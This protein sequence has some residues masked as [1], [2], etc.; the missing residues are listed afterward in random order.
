MGKDREG[1]FHPSKGKPSGLGKENSVELHLKEDG[2]LDQYLETAEKYTDGPEEMPA[3]VRVRHPNR[4]VDKHTENATEGRSARTYSRP[5]S[6]KAESSFTSYENGSSGTDTTA[7]LEHSGTLTRS[8]FEQLANHQADIYITAYLHTHPSGVEVNEKQ[9]LIAFKNILQQTMA[10]LRQVGIDETSAARMLAPGYELLK[11]DTFW[12]TQSQGLAVFIS[13]DLF[14]YIKLPI[15]P[16]EALLMG[17]SFF[18][19]P[20]IP[21]IT[22]REYFYLLVISKKQSKIFRV[23]QFNIQH[24]PVPELPRGIDDV[25]HFEEKDDQNLW[26]TG[27][28]GAGGGANYHGVGAGK[29]DEKENIALYLEEVDETLWENL[30]NKENVPLLLAG[31]DYLL[32]IYRSIA[33]YKNICSENLT[34]SYEHEDIHTL[35]QRALEVMTPYFNERHQKALASYANQSATDLTSSIPADVIPAAYYGRV[36][37]LFVQQN[38]HIWGTFDEMANKLTI[39]DTQQPGDECLLNKAVIKTILTGGEVHILEKEKMPADSSIAAQ[40]R[41]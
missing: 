3:N 2:A 17:P 23:D 7:G 6:K 41:Y 19:H 26:R 12:Q 24:I 38:E 25:V 36:A 14:Q 34:G 9:D 22:A 4:N 27:S 35:H 29:P 16:P 37:H 31:V 40:F 15:A 33:G 10:Q 8:L 5:A 39:H 20:L 1:K 11:N 30:L 28:S 21:L 32:P 18:L 13:N